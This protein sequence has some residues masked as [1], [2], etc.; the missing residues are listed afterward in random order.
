MFLLALA[1]ALGALGAV[2]WFVTQDGPAH[3]YNAQIIAQSL[4]PD[5]PFAPYYIVRWEPLPNWAGHLTL[6]GLISVIPARGVDRAMTAITLAGFAAALV[7]LRWR[8]RGWR[9][10]PTAAPLA[11]LLALNMAWLLGL[12]SFLLGACL[13][14][15][16]LGV[17]WRGRK[18]LSGGRVA[19]LMALLSLGYFC[20][21]ISLGLTVVGLAVLTVLTPAPAGIWWTRLLRTLA[22]TFPLIPLAICYLS[23]SRRGGRLYPQWD[24]LTDPFSIRAWVGQ[25]AWAEPVS[26]ASRF[27]LP[28]VPTPSRGFGLLTPVLWLVLALA[29]ALVAMLRGD[30]ENLTRFGNDRRGWAALA[31]L[32]IFGGLASPDTLGPEHGFY[33]A[34]R[35]VL[36]GLAAVVPLLDLD[37]KGWAGRGCSAAL[38]V[39]LAIQSAFVWEYALTCQHQV[40]ALVRARPKIG[41]SQR[42][43]TVLSDIRTRFRANPLLHA[44]CLLGVDTG[45]ILWSN[46]EAR[47]YYFPVQFRPEI[48]R[49]DPFDLETISL[50]LDSTRRAG[51][52][53]R[54]LERSHQT[55]DV[56]V[57]WGTDPPL[58]AI[59]E[60]WFRV[61]DSE[62][63][64][65]I[66]RPRGPADRSP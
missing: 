27:V 16:T 22:S 26:I 38:A 14:S 31:A 23:L 56:L 51:R 65:R 34:Q 35:V 24:H 66:F 43:A 6:L 58:D 11:V 9:G 63:P 55:I 17:W 45:N 52:W 10:M 46:Y 30:R 36:L 33:L 32:L 37:A 44:D 61:V 13:F 12:T 4:R 8:V 64:V 18:R 15:V 62:G 54:L 5:S 47:F 20:H 2:P 19:A 60:R 49:P 25:M 50:D 21:L 40:G 28:F 1:P 53:A 59:S 48:D 29:L 3:L 39:A 41:R 42:V 57:V 7:W